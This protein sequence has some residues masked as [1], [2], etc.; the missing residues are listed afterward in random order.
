MS[1][2]QTLNRD[3]PQAVAGDFASTNPRVA[4]L[5]GEGALRTAEAITVGIFAF[6]DT[7]TGLVYSEY[8]AGRH[9]GFVHRN[10][11]A[12]VPLGQ[13]ASMVVPAGRE[14]A[15]FTG[16][17]FWVVAPAGGVTAGQ[18][19]FAAEADGSLV[20]GTFGGTPPTDSQATPFKFAKTAAAGEMVKITDKAI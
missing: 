5:A 2:Q 13:A 20:A 15:L 9:P 3:V 4:M 19:V 18:G 11:Q 14:T 12:V 10:N 16:G 1:F 8:V 7:S 17:D 6:A